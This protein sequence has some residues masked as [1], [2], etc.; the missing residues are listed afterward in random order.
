MLES[1]EKQRARPRR[2]RF[3]PAAPAVAAA[4][5]SLATEL[6][7][8][9]LTS[10]ELAVR[11]G[12]AEDWI[13]SRTG[14]HERPIAAPD[15]RLSDYAARAGTAALRRAGVDP[16]QVDLV[17]VATMTQDELTPNAAPIVANLIGA[18]RAGAFDVGAA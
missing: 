9:R 10:A 5:H 1:V 12:V 13:V 15:E 18:H 8:G 7:A 11:L 17:I 16:E 3:E 14:I 6:P 4:F 2:V